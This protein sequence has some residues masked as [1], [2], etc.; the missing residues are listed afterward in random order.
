MACLWSLIWLQVNALSQTALIRAIDV[1]RTMWEAKWV[2]VGR[3][4]FR[5]WERESLWDKIT[6]I[7]RSGQGSCGG[8]TLESALA[9][10]ASSQDCKKRRQPKT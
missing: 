9:T 4:S 8:H 7:N 6:R 10:S 3:K 5:H 1:I 2:R